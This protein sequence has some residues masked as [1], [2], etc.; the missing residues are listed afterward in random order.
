MAKKLG[1]IGVPT[2]MGAFARA[3]RRA[4]GHSGTPASL[5]DS[6]AQASRWWITGTAGGCGAGD[7]IRVTAERR[8]YPPSWRLPRRRRRG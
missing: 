5:N 1:L 7:R 8:T 6:P 4:L 2:S 3:R